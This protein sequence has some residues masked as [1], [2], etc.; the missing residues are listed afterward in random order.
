MLTSILLDHLALAMC[1]FGSS[2]LQSMVALALT[3][4]SSQLALRMLA[5]LFF[6]KLISLDV[7]R[8][9]LFP[10]E[11]SVEGQMPLPGTKLPLVFLRHLPLLHLWSISLQLDLHLI[12]FCSSLM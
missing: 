7:E 10:Q 1:S 9:S 2:S 3:V 11:F 6:F 5:F 4:L 12:G 8:T